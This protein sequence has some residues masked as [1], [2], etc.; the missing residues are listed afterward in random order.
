MHFG[1]FLEERRRGVS[2]GATL[3]ETIDLADA[4]EAGGLDGVWLG[5]IHFNGARSIQS[6]PLALASFLAARTRRVRIGIAVQVLP[7][8]NPLRIAEEA[9]TVD[10]LSEGRL[11]FGIGRSGSARTYDLMGVPY[12]ESQPRFLESLEIIRLAWQGRPFSYEG[13]FYQV[14]NVAVSPTPYQ[15]PHPPLRMAANSPETFPQVARLG[16]PLFIGLRDLDIPA[17]RGQVRAYRDAWRAAGHP[18]DGDVYLRIPVYAAPTEAAAR[19]EPRE[20]MTYF[21]QRHVELVRSGLGRGDTGPLDRRQALAERVAA[22]PYDEV[23]KTRVAFGTA[24]SLRDRLVEIAEDLGLSGI[25][26]EL[27]PSGLLSLDQMRR[28]LDVLTREV[29]PTFR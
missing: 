11:D 12:G 8:G 28:T 10:Q 29:I 22:M 26:A 16:L 4:A 13:K 24:A 1:I 2:E 15:V 27:N 9:A 5:E 19:E 7:L 18:G 20:A 17:Q 23:L 14:R 6:A 3:R 25:V 21:F